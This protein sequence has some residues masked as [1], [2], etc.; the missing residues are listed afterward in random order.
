MVI[1][2][3]LINYLHLFA[4][5]SITFQQYLSDFLGITLESITTKIKHEGK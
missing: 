3:I 2:T 4:K 1:N 5:T